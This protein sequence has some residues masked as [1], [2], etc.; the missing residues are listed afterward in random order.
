MSGPNYSPIQQTSAAQSSIASTSNAQ[1]QQNYAQMQSDMAPAV[2]FNKSITSGNQGSLLTAL[3]PQLANITQGKAAAQ[4]QIM[5]QVG[6]GAARDV[7]LAQNTMNATGQTAALQNSTYTSALDKLA[8]IG[9]GLGS[10]SLNE[11]GAA[12]SGLTGAAQS[13]GTVIQGQ[14]QSK[15]DT[16]SFLG[17]LA[18]A[19]GALGASAIK[20]SD[21]RLKTD[22]EKVGELA[23]VG[24]Y[25]YEFR[26]NPG[27]KEVG[28]I[29]QEVAEIFPDA[30]VVGGE[31]ASVKP[32]MV[33]YPSVLAKMAQM[34]LAA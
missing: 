24:V 22:I 31:D 18:G 34:Q 23:G 20:Y 17:N 25:E 10:F 4:G 14:A 6:P 30:V 3:A 26:D 33:N 12:L 11:T 7:A 2:T 27:K 15:A 28:F 19:G 1:A 21:V 29:A 32:W 9:S 8:N 13:Q 5:E 16:M